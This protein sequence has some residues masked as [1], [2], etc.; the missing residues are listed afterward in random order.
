MINIFVKSL[1]QTIKNAELSNESPASDK[2]EL[3]SL[4]KDIFQ[5]TF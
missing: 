1:I 2:Y 4:E 5:N 3:S